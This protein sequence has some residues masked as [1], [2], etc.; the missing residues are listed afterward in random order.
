MMPREMTLMYNSNN[1]FQAPKVDGLLPHFLVLHRM[2]RKTLASR[3]DY[4]EAILAYA[5]NLLDNLMNPMRF[6]VFEYI[7]DEIGNIATNPLRSCG[8]TPY[9]QYMIEVVTREKLYK[10]VA[11]EPLDDIWYHGYLVSWIW[12]KGTGGPTKSRPTRLNTWAM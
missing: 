11:H 4:L 3:I 7:V 10:D 1:D 8:F 5:Q 12:R 2:V 6:D 9:I